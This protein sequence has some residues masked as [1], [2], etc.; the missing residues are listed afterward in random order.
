MR[1]TNCWYSRISTISRN[2]FSISSKYTRCRIRSII[3][4][5]LN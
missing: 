2:N 1:I 5:L 3:G 4:L